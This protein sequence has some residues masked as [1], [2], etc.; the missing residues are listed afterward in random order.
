MRYNKNI[1]KELLDELSRELNEC[2]AESAA[3]DFRMQTVK[4]RLREEGKSGF[5]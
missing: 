5:L 3:L 1:S 2:A 4:N